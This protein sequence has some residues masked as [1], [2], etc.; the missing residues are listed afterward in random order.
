[1]V[2]CWQAERCFREALKHSS[3]NGDPSTV[4]KLYCNLAL[5]LHSAGKTNEALQGYQEAL[6]RDA[7][8]EL[9]WD[10]YASALQSLGRIK[11]ASAARSRTPPR[12]EL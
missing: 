3:T 12:V 8:L 10:Q 4:A 5:A 1:M 6:E 2:G 11:E 9:C 7:S